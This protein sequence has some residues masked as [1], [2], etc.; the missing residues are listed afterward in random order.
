MF[1]QL[2]F[3]LIL[4]TLVGKHSTILILVKDQF[5]ILMED[6]KVHSFHLTHWALI[7]RTQTYQMSK[8]K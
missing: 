6:L 1:S 8:P 2:L 3:Y 7:Q 4:N 5:S